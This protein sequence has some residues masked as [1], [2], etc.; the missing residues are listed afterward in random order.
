MIGLARLSLLFLAVIELCLGQSLYPQTDTWNSSFTLTPDQIAA[1]DL[2]DAVAHDLQVAIR[3]ERS[4][5]AGGRTVDDPFYDL[6]DDYDVLNPPPPGTI[7]KVEEYTNVTLY[8]IPMSLAMSRFLY[9]TET[10]NGTSAPASGYVLWPYLPRKF[11]NLTSAA[12]DGKKPKFPLL[13]LAHGSSGFTQ[14]CAP[15]NLRALWGEVA[16]TFPFVLAGYA[17]VAPDYLGLGVA[18]TTS[19]YFI[20]PS[21]ANDYFRAIEAAQSAW[22]HLLSKEFVIAGQSQGGGVSWAGAHR[23]AVRPVDGYLGTVAISPFPNVFEAVASEDE[24]QVNGRMLAIARGMSSVYPGFELSEWLTDAGIARLRLMDELQACGD[25]S[26]VLFGAE[27][28]KVQVLKDGWNSTESA[29][30]FQDISSMD[31]KP[32]ASPMMV[33][34]GL[35]DGN[36]YEPSVTASAKKTCDMYPGSHLE[37]YRMVTLMSAL[38]QQPLANILQENITHVPALYAGQHLMMDWIRDRYAG[39]PLSSPGCTQTT[40]KPSRGYESADFDGFADQTWNIV[41][42]AYGI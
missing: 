40:L 39:L 2:S 18:N 35:D 9:M 23:Q 42:N 29:L 7:L 15:S 30:W 4:N 25:A 14:A 10:L 24:A 13:G 21:Q 5:N 20:L 26:G 8:T 34:M 6:P 22:P 36:A 33:L 12:Q 31:G 28:G 1:A 38:I 3:Y 16:T 41:Y 32:F 19:P 17:V 27:E 11:A 37:Y